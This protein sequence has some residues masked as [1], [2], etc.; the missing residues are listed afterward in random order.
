MDE[1]SGQQTRQLLQYSL[2][3]QQPVIDDKDDPADIE[4]IKRAERYMGDYPLKINGN[5]RL[6][7]YKTINTE[8]KH[9]QQ[10]LLKESI[11]NMKLVV[12]FRVHH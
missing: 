11:Y 7:E 2:K 4:K 1:V 6:N 10:I 9:H 5:Y 8:K 3:V 12:K